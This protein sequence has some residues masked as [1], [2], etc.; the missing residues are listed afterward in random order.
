MPN[1]GE[2][3]DHTPDHET[4]GNVS[5]A[6]Q[7]KFPGANQRDW[8]ENHLEHR[9]A[10]KLEGLSDKALTAHEKQHD[11]TKYPPEDRL[12]VQEARVTAVN[13][14]GFATQ[15]EKSEA[16]FHITE[17]VF[18]PVFERAEMAEAHSQWVET[19]NSQPHREMENYDQ[20]IFKQLETLHTEYY[21]TMNAGTSLAER[22]SYPELGKALAGQLDSI[23]EKAIDIDVSDTQIRAIRDRYRE[24]ESVPG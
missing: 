3:L 5:G 20:N 14:I 10:E 18:K 7:T 11:I 22:E 8:T 16:V 24:R 13:S 23:L 4:E 1:R 19:D 2:R 17:S 12:E 15:A 21:A 9:L 6:T